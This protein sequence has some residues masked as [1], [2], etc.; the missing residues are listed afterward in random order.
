MRGQVVMRTTRWHGLLP[1]PEAAQ[2][3]GVKPATIR[4]WKQREYLAPRGLD[5]R[6]RPLYHPDDVIEAERLVRANA[7][8]T[9]GTDP[10]T[11]RHTLA[12]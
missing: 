12:A 2:L 10:R 6:N 4:K 8:K 11:T 7:L 3:V 9:N 1:T 5:E